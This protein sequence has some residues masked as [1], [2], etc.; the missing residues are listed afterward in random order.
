MVAGLFDRAEKIF[1]QLLDEPDYR[2]SAL[3]QLLDIYQRT[4]EWEKAIDM[5]TQLVKMGRQ[6][7]SMISLTIGVN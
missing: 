7:S 5:A 6:S 1:G 3:Q 4:R 2:K